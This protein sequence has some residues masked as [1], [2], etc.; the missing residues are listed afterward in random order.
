MWSVSTM[1]FP[2]EKLYHRQHS[3]RPLGSTLPDL[4]ARTQGPEGTAGALLQKRILFGHLA[5]QGQ[6]CTLT[7][8]TVARKQFWCK[9]QIR[10][11]MALGLW[12]WRR[13]G[14]GAVGRNWIINHHLK[15]H[16]L[17][18]TLLEQAFLFP[19]PSLLH[20]F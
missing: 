12:P 10:R 15:A 19:S 9:H 16:L 8:M 6:H 18:G 1:W 7:S 2:K 4:E 13:E 17:Q 20:H 11:V 3:R 14:S 5:D